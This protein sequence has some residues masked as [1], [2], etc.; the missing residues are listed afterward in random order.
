MQPLERPRAGSKH[1]H[2]SWQDLAAH[3]DQASKKHLPC[4]LYVDLQH[5][6][7]THQAGARVKR[8]RSTSSAH[9]IW[10]HGYIYILVGA[11]YS[12]MRPHW[13]LLLLRIFPDHAFVYSTHLYISCWYR[14]PFEWL[15]TLFPKF[16]NLELEKSVARA[17]LQYGPAAGC[18]IWSFQKLLILD[19]PELAHQLVSIIDRSSCVLHLLALDFLSTRSKTEQTSARPNLLFHAFIHAPSLKYTR[20]SL[21]PFQKKRDL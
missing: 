16:N 13:F 9:E 4:I 7:S 14:H 3:A 6:D 21:P 1:A 2:S 15:W 20:L 11:S 8:T 19:L 18:N 17:D 10:Q 12:C 5:A